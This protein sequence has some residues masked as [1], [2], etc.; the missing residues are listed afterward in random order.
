LVAP[1]LS[2]DQQTWVTCHVAAVA[3]FGGAPWQIWLDNLKTGVIRS[4]IYDPRL[5]RAYAELAKHYIVP[6]DPCRAGRPKDK[7]QVERAIPYV[8]G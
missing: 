7:A 8:S 4:E 2:C 6:L 3:Y 1:V 5:N